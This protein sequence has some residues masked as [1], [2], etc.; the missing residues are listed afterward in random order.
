M[1]SKSRLKRLEMKLQPEDNRTYTLDIFGKP[2]EEVT[3]S[4]G[5]VMSAEAYWDMKPD[6]KNVTVSDPF[7]ETG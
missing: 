1:S 5:T 2:G 6:I 3:V 7:M 4:D